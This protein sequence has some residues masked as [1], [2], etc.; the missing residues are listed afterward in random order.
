MFPYPPE[1]NG[2]SYRIPFIERLKEISV[3]VPSR[4]EWGVL[5]KKRRAMKTT[6]S[7]F[8]SSLEGEWGVLPLLCLQLLQR[9]LSFRTLS[10]KLGV[11]TIHWVARINY[12]KAFPS[13]LGVN[14]GYY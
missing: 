11:I 6:K 5:L 3:S 7:K 8:P 1:V 13:P 9:L 4:G 10:R 12:R 14:G 2:G